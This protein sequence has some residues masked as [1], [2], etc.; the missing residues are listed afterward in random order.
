MGQ[1]LAGNS[2]ARGTNVIAATAA[3]P[4]T[5]QPLHPLLVRRSRCEKARS[6][7]LT[8]PDNGGARMGAVSNTNNGILRPAYRPKYVQMISITPDPAS[9]RGRS[10]VKVKNVS[11][12]HARKL[13]TYGD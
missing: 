9:K 10:R 7:P 4:M 6:R 11:P 3:T 5:G 12:N 8:A 13:R 2:V 1:S